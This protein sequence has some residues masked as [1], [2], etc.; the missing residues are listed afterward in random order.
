MSVNQACKSR[1]R[2]EEAEG[3]ASDSCSGILLLPGPAHQRADPG[4]TQQC[5]WRGIVRAEQQERVGRAAGS[6]R[7]TPAPVAAAMTQYAHDGIDDERSG[8]IM[9]AGIRSNFRQRRRFGAPA[10]TWRGSRCWTWAVAI[11]A[12]L[13]TL[14]AVAGEEPY[15]LGASPAQVIVGQSAVVTISGRGFLYGAL[16]YRCRFEA[17][18]MNA[19]IGEFEARESPMNILT[20]DSAECSTP[21]W[22]LPATDTTLKVQ[23]AGTI[24]RKAGNTTIFRFMNALQSSEPNS[25]GSKGAQKVTII[26][27]GFGAPGR[28]YSCAFTGSGGRQVTSEPCTV[29]PDSN[30]QKLM[31]RTPKWPYPAELTALSVRQN[32]ELITGEL[33]VPVHRETRFHM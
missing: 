4:A 16:D 15:W 2:P 26:G 29:D 28:V 10:Q 30:G 6:Q 21:D 32:D 23:K 20:K 25:G 5:L 1:S 31:C 24:V 18:I 8:N 17:A 19:T 22:D 33:K 9:H 14:F 11:F 13:N 3:H 12:S 7:G 27:V